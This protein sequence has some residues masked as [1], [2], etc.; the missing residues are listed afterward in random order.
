MVT[1]KAVGNVLQMQVC[2]LSDR[3]LEVSGSLAQFRCV[4]LQNL[5]CPF[6]QRCL[7]AGFLSHRKTYSPV[8]TC[9]LCA[10]CVP[11]AALGTGDT[12]VNE[13][14]HVLPRGADIAVG[15]SSPIPR[16]LEP[17]SCDAFVTP[18]VRFSH[19]LPC[20]FCVHVFV[21]YSVGFIHLIL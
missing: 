11:C 18:R 10:C 9:L 5:P 7:S 21:P 1:V 13:R 16:C 19:F 15:E 17:S 8:D 6:Q 3:L 14:D 20:N 12:A 4:L 2:T